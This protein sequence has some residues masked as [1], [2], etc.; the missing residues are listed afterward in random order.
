MVRLLAKH[1]PAGSIVVRTNIETGKKQ[2]D[3]TRNYK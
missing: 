2:V 1:N 3:V